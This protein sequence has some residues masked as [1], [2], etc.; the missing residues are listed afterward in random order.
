MK[1]ILSVVLAFTLVLSMSV[2]AYAEVTVNGETKGPSPVTYDGDAQLVSANESGD[3]LTVNGSVAG[4]ESA[5]DAVFAADTA[6]ITVSESV[7]KTGDNSGFAVRANS[8]SD[9]TV[10]KNITESGKSGAIY[11]SNNSKV[12]VGGNVSESDSGYAI[13]AY[14]GS[15]VEVTGNVTESGEK[16][17]IYATGSGTIITVEGNVTESDGG[18]AIEA[19][20]SDTTVT[21]KGDVTENDVGN[22]IYTQEGA[23]VIVYGSVIENDNGVAINALTGSTVKV[24]GDVTGNG[25]DAAIMAA[26][27]A[28]VI[29]E[30]EVE[31]DVGATGALY[32]GQL[33]GS[34]KAGEDNIHYLI[35]TAAEGSVA[36]NAIN[37]I[38]DIVAAETIDGV[39]EN[40][41][42]YTT[43]ADTAALSGKTI[44][45]K[46]ATGKILTVSGFSDANVTYVANEDGTVTFTVGDN[47]KG[48]LQNLVLVIT[49][50]PSPSPDPDPTPTPTPD[51]D[52]T[53]TPKPDPQPTP[54]PSEPDPQPTTPVTSPVQYTE[55]GNPVKNYVAN[56]P[57]G[58]N[59]PLPYIT[60]DGAKAGWQ[61]I[62][63]AL[64]AHKANYKG[65]NVDALSVTM[66]GSATVDSQLIIDAHDKDIPLSFVLDDEVTVGIP[67][68]NSVLS[69]QA[70]EGKATYFKV[71]SMTTAEA[72]SVNKADAG[73][74]PSD[75]VAIGGN[76]NTPVVLTLCSNDKLSTDKSQLM[77]ISFNASKA[78]YKKGDKVYLYCGTSLTG[79]AMYKMGTVDK[80]GFVT[81]SVPMVSNYWTIGSTNMRDKLFRN[82]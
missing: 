80:D 49:D 10:E 72:V 81:F 78:G 19:K 30:G 7:T 59:V 51:P 12:Y 2:P 57:T 5:N 67:T 75:L 26:N 17:A 48:G 52:P 16:D 73:L 21:V 24:G 46:P 63:E 74:L 6:K 47:F 20:G 27:D 32:L 64:D 76:E 29:V 54:A 66:N 39:T 8:G 11:T 13:Q 36:L 42:K 4:D 82:N 9:V 79:I 38:S 25:S 58:S 3:S 44:T 71:S 23:V 37:L 60:T 34:I 62:D 31:G 45:L 61:T 65:K 22:A 15:S 35:G 41:Y 69:D 43:T 70:K 33:E 50:K 18:H 14:F 40:G 56:N 28:T 1:K 53:P 68:A 55:T 77:T